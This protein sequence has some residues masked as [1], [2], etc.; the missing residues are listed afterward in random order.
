MAI[1][2]Y[3]TEEQRRRRVSSRIRNEVR[4]QLTTDLVEM[5]RLGKLPDQWTTVAQLN[6]LL[7]EAGYWL[8]SPH[9]MARFMTTDTCQDVLEKAMESLTCSHPELWVR[10]GDRFKPAYRDWNAFAVEKANLLQQEMPTA[11][12]TA[13]VVGADGESVLFGHEN[14]RHDPR[15]RE[16]VTLL[17]EILSKARIPELGFG[18]SDDG[19]TWVI[20]VW[21]QDQDALNRALMEAWQATYCS[22]S[23]AA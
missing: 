1:D 8:S 20:V 23:S 10:A 22:A 5:A 14:Y 21:S 18:L 4:A 6:S 7:D 2:V 16:E 15:V 11:N 19:K 9:V 12:R 3:E 13:L 17:R